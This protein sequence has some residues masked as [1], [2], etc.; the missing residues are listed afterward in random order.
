MSNIGAADSWENQADVIGEQGAKDSNDVSTKFSTLNVNAVEFVPSF[1]MPSQANE[2][3]ESPSS[4]QKSESGSTNSADS[5]VLNGCGERGD[6]GDGGAASASPRVEEPP[7]VP[8]AAAAPVPAPAA[9]PVPPDV[10]PTVDSWEAEADDA[11]LTPEENNEPDEEEIDQQVQN[12]EDGELTKKVP[13]KK[14]PR[15]EDTRSK[16]E[17]VNV[18]FIGHVDAGKSTIGGQI[19]SLT[20]MVDKRTLD[21]YEREA[22]EKSR[23]SWYLSWALDTN[24]E[25]R[26]KGKTVEVGR[27]YFETEKKHFTILDAPGHKSFVPNMIGGAAQADLAVLVISAR[28]GEFET[29]FDRGGQT[30]EHAMLAK[31]AGVKHLVA[32]VNKMDDPTVNWDEKRY[33]ECRDKILPYL[34]KLGFNTAK[35]LSFLPVSGQTGQGLLE[36]VS[37]DICSWYTGPSFIQLIDEL[38]S[39]NRKMDGPFI[40]PVVDKY[41]DMGT[42]LMGKVEAGTTRKGSTL[43]LMPNRVQVNVDQLWSD[44]IEV[45]SIGPGEN[46]KVKLKGIEEEDVSPGFVLCDIAEPITTGRALICLVDK[47]T[48]DK[49]KT[50][51]RFVKQ[52]QVAIMRIECAGIICLE[53]FKKFAQM[54]RFTLRDENKTIAIGKV[55]KQIFKLHKQHV[56][57]TKTNHKKK[58]INHDIL[59]SYILEEFQV[60]N[61]NYSGNA[62]RNS[63]D[64]LKIITERNKQLVH[65]IKTKVEE[66]ERQQIQYG[67]FKSARKDGKQQI[68]LQFFTEVKKESKEYS[69][70]LLKDTNTKRY[71][72]YETAYKGDFNQVKVKID[73]EASLVTTRDS[74]VK[75]LIEFGANVN[76][77]DVLHATPLHRAASLGRNN[78]VE[79]LLSHNIKVDPQDST[80]STPFVPYAICDFQKY[81]NIIIPPACV[82]VEK[83]VITNI[84]PAP[85]EHWE[86]LFIF[87]MGND[88]DVEEQSI[89]DGKLEECSGASKHI[90]NKHFKPLQIVMESFEGLLPATSLPHTVF[91]LLNNNDNVNGIDIT[92]A[93]LQTIIRSNTMEQNNTHSISL[94]YERK[95]DVDE[96]QTANRMSSDIISS[97]QLDKAITSNRVIVA[98][99]INGCDSS[100]ITSCIL[101][102]CIK[103]KQAVLLIT[104]HN[105]LLHYQNVGLKMNYNLEKYIDSGLIKIFKLDEVLVN[106]LLANETDSLQNIFCSLNEN[107]NLI[108]ANNAVVNI[109]FDGVSHLFDMQHSLRDVTNE[110]S[111]VTVSSAVAGG[112]QRGRLFLID[113]AGSE[114][115]GLRAR[116][117]EGAHINR[118]LLA[119]ANCI[120]AL[121][122]GARYVNYRDSKLTRLLREV[123]G[124]RCRTAMVAHVA[125]GGAHR[126]TTRSTLHYAQRASSITNKVERELVATPMHMSQY[127]K[128]KEEQ[129]QLALEVSQQET[130]ESAAH[131]KSLREA[132]VSTFK[133]Q[134]R[135]RRRLMELDS[136]LLGLALDAE[137]QHAAISHWE[138][139]F[140]RLYKPINMP[141]SRLSTHQSYRGGTGA[142][143]TSSVGN[144]RAEA[145][146][147]VEQAWSELAGVE[148]EQEAARAERDRV[149]RQLEQVR[150]RGAQLEQE[151]PARI[152]SGPEREVLALVCRVHELEADKL[153]LQGER[154]ARA[155]ELRRRDL[156]LQRRD[157]QRRLS[158]EI[159]TRQRRA[160]EDGEPLEETGGTSQTSQ[161]TGSDAKEIQSADENNSEVPEPET[162]EE[163]TEVI[164]PDVL[165]ILGDPAE[166]INKFGP[167]INENIASRWTPILKKGLGK[168]EKDT[169]TKQYQV[170]SNC[171]LLQSPKLNP[172]INSAISDAAKNR[173]KK[174]ESTQQQLG[175]G[176]TALGRAMTLAITDYDKEKM[177]VI[178]HMN[179]AARILTDLHFNETRGRKLLITPTLDKNFLELVKDV[180]H[181]EYLYGKNLSENI[182]TL[183]SIENSSK[184]IKKPEQPRGSAYTSS[185]KQKQGNAYNPPRYQQRFTPSPRGAAR[186]GFRKPLPPPRRPAASQV[187]N[188]IRKDT[189][190]AS[191]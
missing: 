178:K 70:Q 28:K 120:M 132:I 147:A 48:G 137:R 55:L 40:M 62:C 104:T 182:K 29:G 172:E 73:Q 60:Q 81:R 32:L 126:E 121:S 117:L 86:P 23:E 184:T 77:A 157:A 187:A 74:I 114:R 34:K 58:I 24:Q 106:L 2:T 143:S 94:N 164:D 12:T 49:S 169:I 72:V 20:G 79:L 180:G 51:P 173:D 165:L 167:E 27:A 155:H 152:S 21:K 162:N 148:R 128:T 163:K 101:G 38:P 116:R 76:E 133:Q 139:R 181:D 9:P 46:V 160:L 151:L 65:E 150:L 131:L 50:R 36:R 156:A 158:D 89:E 115:A 124:G 84:K 85:V 105:S 69:V 80:G 130:E 175:V 87:D 142:S 190:R 47:K 18:V 1:C 67:K 138:A 35:D 39:L 93:K 45:T 13:K 3:S 10:S 125:P 145:E 123:L 168:E 185:G 119:L 17:H 122:G 161:I 166:E 154:A 177:T 57:S 140:N 135:L 103:N 91:F 68:F 44:D 88:G 189:P 30:R 179:N 7:P 113:L 98:K 136:H 176:L 14:P 92:I 53:P 11:L 107:M 83:G 31:T 127:R 59:K 42:V 61:F 63:D 170:P 191:R 56:R 8:P 82:Q 186:G 26:D 78:I 111:S 97:L 75:L 64:E 96:N 141:S 171:T 146:V 108:K 90:K 54:G 174:L 16:K 118:S 134:M 71:E 153:A 22:R 159:I 43:F 129:Q 5:P 109:I 188:Q 149:E 19:M 37:E 183:K 4:P 95:Y 144:E 112:V 25:E 33:N 6:S 100:F 99:E 102:H 52:D 66:Y 15:V 110:L 41:K